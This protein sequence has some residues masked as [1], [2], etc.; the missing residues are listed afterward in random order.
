MAKKDPLSDTRRERFRDYCRSKGWER[1]EGGW[2]IGEIAKAISKPYSQTSNLMNGHGSFGATLA[3]EIE[4]AL[5]LGHGYFDGVS[6]TDFV[7]VPRV[8]VHVSAGHGTGAQIEEVTGHLKFSRAFLRTCGVQTGSARVVDVR[9]PSME[10]TIKDGA[11]LLVSA[12]NK[13]PVENQIFA[14]VSPSEGLIVKRLVRLDGQWVAR[15]DNRDYA[16]RP[17]N[18]GAPLS[19]IGRAIWMGAKL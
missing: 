8:N 19:I 5:G 14:L 13:E 3:R 2:A 6:D 12:S 18:D 15:S 1:P 11:V 16:D 10:P 17:I 9:G 4:D 7:D